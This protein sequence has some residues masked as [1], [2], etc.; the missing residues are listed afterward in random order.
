M[1]CHYRI[2]VPA[3]KVGLPE[4]LIGILPGGGGTQRLPRLAGAQTA[5]EMIT[6]GRHVPAPEAAQTRHP[7]RCPPGRRRSADCR[8]RL[9]AQ[10]RG[11][12]AF[13]AGARQDRYRR[14][15]YLRRHAQID[16]SPRPQ[17]E[18]AVSL[19]RRGGSR[20]HAAF[21]R[22]CPPRGGTVRRTGNPTRRRRCATPS[23]P[24]A[25][26]P[27]CRTCRPTLQPR[28]FTERR[29]SSAPARWAAA[30]PCGSPISA[31]SENHGRD[32]GSP[33]SRHGAYP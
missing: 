6:S 33:R 4:V 29:P 20:L 24:N 12:P 14:P 27:N 28:D 31:S 5:L 1:A 7:R 21:R 18:G 13:A 32:P 8:G 11:Y 3:A 10:N 26:S 17:S 15:R 19:H 16:R 30:S 23:S 22:R 9:C 2:A 25:R